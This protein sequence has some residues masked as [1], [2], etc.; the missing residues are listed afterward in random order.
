MNVKCGKT[1]AIGIG[2]VMLFPLAAS[3][4]YG[5]PLRLPTVATVR[6]AVTV[7]PRAVSCCTLT[8]AAT[9]ARS[10]ST[11]VSKPTAS[12]RVHGNSLSSNKPQHLYGIFR[13]DTNTGL[14]R[15]YKFGISS[16][17]SRLGHQ[18]PPSMRAKILAPPRDYSNRA[19][20]QVKKLNNRAAR[21]NE[22]AKYTTRVLQRIPSNSSGQLTARQSMAAMEQQA[23]TKHYN[24]R[25][26]V[27]PGNSRPKPTSFSPYKK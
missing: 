26:V 4:Q 18:L 22:P 3:A 1:M 20:Q 24:T 14:T 9:A 15:V 2:L 19:L 25:G 27:P 10:A 17:S 23:V 12:P 5:R 16:G 13:T 7:P 21:L 6:A 8:R 11:A